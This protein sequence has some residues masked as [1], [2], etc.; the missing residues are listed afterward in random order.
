VTQKRSGEIVLY[1]NDNNR[2]QNLLRSVLEKNGFVV[3]TVSDPEEAI[4]SCQ[5]IQFDMA[6]LNY[7][8]PC[9]AA[10]ELPGEIKFVRPDVPIIMISGGAVIAEP[11]LAFVDAHF[12]AG[13]LLDD[14]IATMQ[15][16]LTREYIGSSEKIAATKWADTTSNCGHRCGSGKSSDL[17]MKGP[18]GGPRVGLEKRDSCNSTRS[19]S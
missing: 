9:P 17:N 15:M 14:V 10:R 11:D 1:V 18:L 4:R 6:L 19:F 13:T 7:P 12:G 5:E 2:I 16:L 3:L 8:M